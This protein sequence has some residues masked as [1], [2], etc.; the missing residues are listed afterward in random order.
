MRNW[1]TIIESLVEA[2]IED[3]GVLGDLDRPGSMQA[4]DLKAIQNPKWQAKLRER[5]SK[6][7]Y[8]INVYFL[9]APNGTHDYSYTGDSGQTY[10]HTMHITSDPD[11]T[12][13]SRLGVTVANMY[14]YAG[15]YGRVRFETTFGFVPPNYQNSISVLLAQ[16]EGSER[17]PLTQWMVAHR[18]I[19]A[20]GHAATKG[21]VEF[22]EVASVDAALYQQFKS[23]L[24][25][26]HGSMLLRNGKYKVGS[27]FAQSY[28][29]IG[30][31]LGTTKA[32]REGR[33]INAGEFYVEMGA[34]YLL[35]GRVKLN[36]TGDSSLDETAAY[37]EKKFNFGFD[38]L[39]KA[40]VGKMF[41]L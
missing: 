24:E 28:N 32:Q 29:E 35:T 12:D 2:P 34:Q 6:T 10:D 31:A 33:M 40:A 18:I 37:W 20:F 23:F 13:R 25:E 21:Y 17:V 22:D 8:A 30:K 7:P 5:F 36:R 26:A 4:D 11:G 19:H 1:I 38:R 16:N 14:D 39:L 3:M 9:N 27:S 15:T 41:V